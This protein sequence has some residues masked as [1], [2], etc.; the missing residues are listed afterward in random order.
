M[1]G[2][3]VFDS[4]VDRVF[5]YIYSLS[6]SYLDLTECP[7]MWPYCSQPMYYGAIPTIVNVSTLFVVVL[8]LAQSSDYALRVPRT[9]Y[10][11]HYLLVCLPTISARLVIDEMILKDHKIQHWKKD[12]II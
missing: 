7:Y 8:S 5:L 3:T 12:M 2:K 4:Y 9:W 10:F 11:T 6:P 1:V